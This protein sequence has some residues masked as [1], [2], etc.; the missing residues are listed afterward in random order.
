M[1]APVMGGKKVMFS[2][3]IKNN[4]SSIAIILNKLES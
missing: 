4:Y 3:F 2:F 1:N